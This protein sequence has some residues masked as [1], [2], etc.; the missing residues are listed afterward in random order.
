M[1]V[2]IASDLHGF[3]PELEGGDILILAGDYTKSDTLSEWS[4]FFCWLKKQNYRKKILISGNHDNFFCTGFPKNQQE[5]DD[6]KEVNEFLN[7]L[8]YDSLNDFDYLCDSGIEF[9]GLK[10]WGSPWTSSFEGINPNCKAF[11]I[12]PSK[13]IEDIFDSY[14]TLIPQDTD[15]L[16]THSPPYRI[17]DKTNKGHYVGSKSL[18]QHVLSRISPKLHAFGHI[19]ECG[20]IMIDSVLTKFVNASIVNEK[21]ENVNKPIRIIL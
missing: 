12:E 8:G 11:T 18:R 16:V 10:I 6:L 15:I 7:D 4:D 19:H 3:F 21:Y 20:G 14:Y 1:I 13:Y 2:D 17:M 5:A 9:E